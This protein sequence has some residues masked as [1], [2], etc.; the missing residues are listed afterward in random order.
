MLFE[1]QDVFEMSKQLIEQLEGKMK[2]TPVEK[3]LSDLF[4]G[5]LNTYISCI[6]VDHTSLRS[7]DFWDLEMNVRNNRTLNDS[8]REFVEVEKM[9]GDFQWYTGAHGLQDAV[10]GFTFEMFPPILQLRLKRYQY[11]FNLNTM[12]KLDDYHEFPEEFDAS[13]YLSATAD[14]SEPCTYLLVGVIVHDGD[15]NK[16]H[17]YVF[18][19]SAKHRQFYK[20]DDERVNLATNKEAIG[21]NFGDF[22][23]GMSAYMLIYVR[24]SRLGEVF[25]DIPDS[26]IPH[27][28][29]AS[30]ALKH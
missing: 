26:A 19:R 1:P 8:F 20:F 22:K 15:I 16:G 10:K 30:L 3:A 2:G 14:R 28:L 23:R 13:P 9:D 17:N 12:T 21:D 7:E 5:R 27:H 4:V 6:N 18:M 29:T 24:N 25:A 11:D